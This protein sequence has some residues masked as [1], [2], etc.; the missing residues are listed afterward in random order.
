MTAFLLQN[1]KLNGY[2]AISRKNE[3]ERGK[4]DTFN[5]IQMF[6]V[7]KLNNNNNNNNNNNSTF[8]QQGCIK[9]IKSDS[10]DIYNVFLFQINAVNRRILKK[11]KSY[12]S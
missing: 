5:T 12:I 9:L 3:S 4:T 10:K 7:R 8:I 11:K 1:I 6:G 2:D